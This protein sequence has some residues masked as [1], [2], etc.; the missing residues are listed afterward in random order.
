MQTDSIKKKKCVFHSLF[1]LTKIFIG[2][3]CFIVNLRKLEIT[4]IFNLHELF[5]IVKVIYVHCKVQT[6]KE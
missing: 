6:E 4:V 3:T 2:I 5:L 1:Y